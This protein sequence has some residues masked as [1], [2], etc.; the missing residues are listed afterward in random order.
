[1]PKLPYLA[2]AGLVL[3]GFTIG[4]VAGCASSEK[5][6]AERVLEDIASACD[7]HGN[8]VYRRDTAFGMA[9]D[10]AVVGDDPTCNSPRPTMR[11]TGSGTSSWPVTE[12]VRTGGGAA[13]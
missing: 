6:T 3:G 12:V 13:R 9:R 1:M 10:I 7:S 11:W 4:S 5:T 8:R 2:L